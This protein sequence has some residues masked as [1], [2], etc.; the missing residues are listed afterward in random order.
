MMKA[1]RFNA[2]IPRYAAGLAMA[3]VSSSLLWSGRSCTYVEDVPRPELIGPDWVRVRTR[4]GGICGSDLNAIH[5][6]ASP[7]FSALVS[8]PYTFGHENVGIVDEVGA[9]VAGWKAGQRVVVEPTLWCKPRGFEDLCEFCARGEI[10]RC[11]RVTE[12][13][14]K[15]G[16]SVG[17]CADTSGSWSPYFLAHQS[18]L[19][20]VPD[21]VSDANALMV[22]PFAVAL[23]AALMHRPA[24]DET[25]LILGSGS[26]GLCMLAALRA[27][28]CKSRILVAARYPFQADAARKLGASEVLVGDTYAEV[29]KR[30]NAKVLKPTLGKS[31]VVGGVDWTFECVGSDSALDDSLRLTQNGGAVVVVGVP[32]IAR[33]VDWTSVF[34]KELTVRASYIYNHVDLFEGATW[35]TFDLA[36][37]LMAS[38][39]IDLSW[40]VTHRF[41]LDQY[42]QALKLHG[43]KGSSGLIKAVFEFQ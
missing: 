9:D 38:N 34:I 33:N 2:T 12:G 43:Q 37:T 8:F 39:K 13:A 28:G 5:L 4:L 3:K 1:I 6:H 26:I 31:V 35:K 22:E 41:R 18:Q 29:A 42:D 19:Y 27:V 32:G 7:Y 15:P 14:L 16:L 36:L 20:A 10:N 40:M 11:V 23:H 17:N 30:T 21:T 25:V 24:D